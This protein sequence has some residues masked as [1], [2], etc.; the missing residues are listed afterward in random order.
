MEKKEWGDQ[1]MKWGIQPEN[2]FFGNVNP[3]VML[4]DEQLKSIQ[5]DICQLLLKYNL[6]WMYVTTDVPSMVQFAKDK[7][8]VFG[9]KV[10]A[11]PGN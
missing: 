2:T 11:P 5:V 7:G 10:D 8:L 9:V 4:T 3:L 6:Q 1:E